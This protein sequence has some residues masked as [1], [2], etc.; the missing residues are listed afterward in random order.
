MASDEMNNE[1]IDLFFNSSRIFFS[2]KNFYDWLGGVFK[3]RLDHHYIF[4]QLKTYFL[5]FNN[6]PFL[7]SLLDYS[8]IFILHDESQ[9]FNNFC[10]GMAFWLELLG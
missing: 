9:I 8:F 7:N 10:E 1:I 4:A 5:H 3:E 2:S 6:S